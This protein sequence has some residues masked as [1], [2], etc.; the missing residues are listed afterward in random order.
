LAP[1]RPALHQPDP[2]W[3]GENCAEGDEKADEEYDHAAYAAQQAKD[4]WNSRPR[5]YRI[6]AASAKAKQNLGIE[7]NDTTKTDVRVR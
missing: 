4:E 3:S 6:A 7:C 5:N 1:F 2:K